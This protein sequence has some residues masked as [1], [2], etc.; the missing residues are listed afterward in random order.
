LIER[1]GLSVLKVETPG[2][3][4]IDILVNNAGL[5][6][7][8]FWRNFVAQASLEERQEWQNFVAS[9]GLSSHMFVVCECPA[10]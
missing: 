3:L 8:R 2:K 6:K 10:K 5:I 7:D 9:H 1:V 4:D